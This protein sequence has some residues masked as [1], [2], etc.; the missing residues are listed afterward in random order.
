MTRCTFLRAGYLSIRDFHDVLMAVLDARRRWYYIGLVLRISP[1]ALDAIQMSEQGNPHG[2]L[3]A[4][5]KVWLRSDYPQPTW[6]ALEKALRSPMV[7]FEDLADQL[8]R[9]HYTE[10][11]IHTDSQNGT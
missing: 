10:S 1:G 8:S 9:R 4:M 3:R 5:I 11:W 6:A 2:C 7:G